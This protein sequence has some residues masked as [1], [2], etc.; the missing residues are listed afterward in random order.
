M[1]GC[2]LEFLEYVEGMLYFPR[3]GEKRGFLAD[4]GSRAS[5]EQFKCSRLVADKTTGNYEI[6]EF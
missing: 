5:I 1:S 3:W 6:S 2:A 4:I